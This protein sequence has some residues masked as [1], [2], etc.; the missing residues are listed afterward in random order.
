M[1][2]RNDSFLREVNEEV[3][4]EQLLKLWEQYGTYVV[5]VVVFLFL[6]LAAY[7]WRESR[8]LVFEEQT[9][10]RFEAAT[11]LAA[12]GKAGEALGTFTEIAKDGPAG[13]RA[14]ARLRL[15]SEH[16]KAGRT[17]EALTA[18]EALST[19]S[20]VDEVLRDFAALQAAVLRLDHADWT[21]M[22]N[23][24]TPLVEDK[25]PW[26]A[27][28]RE[29]L[30]IAAFKSGHLDEATR[31]FEQVLGDRAATTGLSR[32][33]Q[34]MLAVLTDAAAAKGAPQAPAAVKGGS[35]AKSTPDAAKGADG[36]AAPKK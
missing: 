30:G 35:D 18:Y 32:R 11:R 12:E 2:D 19:D 6:G 7:K 34:E 4:R 31:L 27:Q 8:A 21:E 28:A 16:A 22:K 1:V 33:A 20:A 5:A 13:Y 24:L 14:L 9:G 17:A 3:R 23:R 10:A 29:L 15:A 36:G 25:R 26:R